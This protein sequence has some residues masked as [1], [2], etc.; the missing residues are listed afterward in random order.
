MATP[1]L[2]L[3]FKSGSKSVDEFH[4]LAQ[5]ILFKTGLSQ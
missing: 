5:E 2:N 4:Q 3:D 1:R